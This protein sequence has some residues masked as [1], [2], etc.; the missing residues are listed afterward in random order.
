[1]KKIGLALLAV[2][3]LGVVYVST[4]T[5][6]ESD[7]LVPGTYFAFPER[8]AFATPAVARVLDG[9]WQWRVGVFDPDY[10]FD[11]VG[12]IEVIWGLSTDRI[13]PAHDFDGDGLD[14][15]TVYRPATGV[16]YALRSSCE[17]TCYTAFSVP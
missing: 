16:W 4:D 17:F 11:Y 7:V 3:V 14:E 13:V 12:T 10:D 6:T 8:N 9:S 2:V 15:I 1:M 5:Q